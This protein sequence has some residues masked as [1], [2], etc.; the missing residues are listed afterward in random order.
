MEL[1]LPISPFLCG[2]WGYLL[3]ATDRSE[4]KRGISAASKSVQNLSDP[5]TPRNWNIITSTINCSPE[6]A[7]LTPWFRLLGLVVE[8]VLHIV[9]RFLY[10]V[11][12]LL[13]WKRRRQGGIGNKRARR[14]NLRVDPDG[15]AADGSGGQDW[16]AGEPMSLILI[17]EH[18]F[19]DIRSYVQIID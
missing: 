16:D 19:L 15:P 3:R 12:T 6:D 14:R 11:W 7:I 13:N 2:Q 18:I 8:D 10:G 9:L 1:R 17:L 4:L 5:E